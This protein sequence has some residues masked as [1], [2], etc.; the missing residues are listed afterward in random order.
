MS[1]RK[2]VLKIQIGGGLLVGGRTASGDFV[3]AVTSLDKEG[4]PFIPASTLK[5]AL[6]ESMARL[7]AA[8]P[9]EF[10]NVCSV[11]KP[12]QSNSNSSPCVVCRIFGE[13]GQEYANFGDDLHAPA[14]TMAESKRLHLGDA[15]PSRDQHNQ[16]SGTLMLRHGIGVDRRVR[17]V[18][19]QRLFTRKIFHSSEICFMA[20]L[21]GEV[22]DQDWL[23]FTRTLPTV[24]ALGN[25]KSRGLGHVEVSFV[26]EETPNPSHSPVRISVETTDD[27]AILR[28]ELKSNMTIGT[29][30]GENNSVATLDRIPGSTI[31]GALGYAL[32]H[33]GI[34]PKSPE[35]HRVFIDPNTR[36]LFSDALPSI[37]KSEC[38]KL[39]MVSPLTWLH[40]PKK[41]HHDD[42]QPFGTDSLIRETFARLVLQH[43]G[44]RQLLLC[45]QCHTPLKPY[46]GKTEGTEVA[47]IEKRMV[48]RLAT[49][50]RFGAYR[51]GQLFSTEEIEH[52]K[53]GPFFYATVSRLNEETK[54][55][56][57]SCTATVRMGGEKYRGLG[58]VALSWLPGIHPRTLKHR[59][60][61]FHEKVKPL[62]EALYPC[63]I[64]LDRDKQIQL[65]P[66]KHLRLLVVVART[67]LACPADL[68]P[69]D[70]LT[71]ALFQKDAISPDSP[72]LLAEHIRWTHRSGWDTGGTEGS[73]PGPR[74]VQPVVAE[75]SV[76][77]WVYTPSSLRPLQELFALE[78]DG[79]PGTCF[80]P[81]DPQK[82]WEPRWM[83]L[84]RI[85][86]NSDIMIPSI[87]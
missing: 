36:L 64:Q 70:F 2:G 1:R 30:Q 59:M 65:D 43:G 54:K 20:P 19:P 79:V 16:A 34:S 17:S 49:D 24:F 21:E 44:E 46:G 72:V 83:G 26:P 8:L 86:I 32:I 84:N 71:Q 47:D 56:L 69:A 28:I 11:D 7:A 39:P 50:R 57:Q 33:S 31:Q 81:K 67:P 12:C 25:S 51:D 35:F 48:T 80:L 10:E 37:S 23:L 85:F 78:W 68:Q 13:I 27:R 41:H 61:T 40:C 74:P 18:A 82:A 29:I 58:E 55:L 9:E 66:N 87:L 3:D 6:R 53:A 45:P 14:C 38:T 42:N 5:G 76:W 77:L 52:T 15:R 22:S 75:G 4:L 60:E 63:Q 62:L 73:R